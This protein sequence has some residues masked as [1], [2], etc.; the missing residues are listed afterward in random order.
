M[1]PPPSPS[2]WIRLQLGSL[3]LFGATFPLWVAEKKLGITDP[4]ILAFWRPPKSEKT[5]TGCW[6]QP[7]IYGKNMF[8]TTNQIKC[9]YHGLRTLWMNRMDMWKLIAGLALWGAILGNMG[10]SSSEIPGLRVDISS[11]QSK[12]DIS[13]TTGRILLLTVANAKFSH[14]TYHW[15]PSH[16]K[17]VGE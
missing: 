11:W 7:S 17:L 6:F 12:M 3:H 14:Q 13:Q 5:S 2:S 15:A 9:W 16:E 1:I 4:K 10:V 8:Q